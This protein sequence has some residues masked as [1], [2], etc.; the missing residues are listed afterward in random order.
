MLGYLLECK[1]K[2]EEV[3]KEELWIE[4]KFSSTKSSKCCWGSWKAE[5]HEQLLEVTQM[6]T[7]MHKNEKKHLEKVED[8]FLKNLHQSTRLNRKMPTQRPRR[9]VSMAPMS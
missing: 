3:N 4:P 2:G 1:T 8:H 7:T 6:I 9:R 5:G